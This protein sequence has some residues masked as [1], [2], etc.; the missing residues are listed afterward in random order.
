MKNGA[1]TLPTRSLGLMPDNTV[2]ALKDTLG[3]DEL[4]LVLLESIEEYV[5]YLDEGP[6]VRY[7]KVRMFW[8]WIFLAAA[9]V[10]LILGRNGV[11]IW[12]MHHILY[13]TELDRVTDQV[14]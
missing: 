10:F 3:V 11:P 2:Q 5:D 6:G 7:I 13:R 12:D 14:H 1:H 4:D 9:V 8:F